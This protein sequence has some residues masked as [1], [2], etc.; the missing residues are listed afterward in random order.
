ME[1]ISKYLR[2]AH[3]SRNN[4][5]PNRKC[6]NI[7]SRY[8]NIVISIVD[9]YRDCAGARKTRS[10]SFADGQRQRRRDRDKVSAEKTLCER[11][12]EKEEEEEER[13][14]IDGGERNQREKEREGEQDSLEPSWLTREGAR[15]N[16]RPQEEVPLARLERWGHPRVYKNTKGA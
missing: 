2:I 13:R 8:R 11:S 1:R 7:A 3:K 16:E 6:R 14:R 5:P 15:R 12:R 4:S 10:F 9:G